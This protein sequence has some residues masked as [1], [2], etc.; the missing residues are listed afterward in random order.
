MFN[1]EN[2]A[3]KRTQIE[4]VVLTRENPQQTGNSGTLAYLRAES[5]G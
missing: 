1:L 5:D 2:S 3:Q 4:Q